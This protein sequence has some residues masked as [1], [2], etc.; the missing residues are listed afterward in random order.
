MQN[1]TNYLDREWNDT[2]KRLP[3]FVVDGSVV[4]DTRVK[5]RHVDGRE[6]STIYQGFGHFGYYPYFDDITHWKLED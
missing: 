4:N 2:R 1:Y 6:E 5:V 3:T